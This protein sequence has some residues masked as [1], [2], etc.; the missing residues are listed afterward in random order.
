VEDSKKGRRVSI[1]GG[2]ANNLDQI[3][4][5]KNY[6][7]TPLQLIHHTLGKDLLAVYGAAGH[8][9]FVSFFVSSVKERICF[10][11]TSLGTSCYEVLNLSFKPA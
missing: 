2:K 10:C 7:C 5:D 11:M 8:G 4:D 9:G 6:K 1:K 3:R